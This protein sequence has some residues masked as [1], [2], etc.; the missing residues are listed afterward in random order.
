MK[1]LSVKVLLNQ[2]SPEYNI[3]C[4]VNYYNLFYISVK[5]QIDDM[6]SS[7]IEHVNNK[8]NEFKA[9]FHARLDR[10]DRTLSRPMSDL[11]LGNC[12]NFVKRINYCCINTTKRDFFCV[13][14]IHKKIA[15]GGSHNL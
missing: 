10:I 8:F 5:E 4:A 12:I 3:N 9:E 1:F 14:N 15:F 13:F 11:S 6:K 7:M 2:V